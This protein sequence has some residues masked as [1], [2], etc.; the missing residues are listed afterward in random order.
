MEYTVTVDTQHVSVRPVPPV[1]VLRLLTAKEQAP[2]VQADGSIQVQ[3]ESEKYYH[4]DGE[5]LGTYAG[6]CNRIVTGLTQAGHH[7]V[8]HDER[9]DLLAWAARPGWYEVLA[10]M[11]FTSRLMPDLAV[12]EQLDAADRDLLNAVVSAWQGQIIVRHSGSTARGIALICHLYPLANILIP[13]ASRQKVLQLQRELSMWLEEPVQALFGQEANHNC[14]IAVCNLQRFEY[15]CPEDWSII[16]YPSEQEAIHRATINGVV[17]HLDEHRSYAFVMAKAK[18]NDR[19]ALRLEAASGQVIYREP[20]RSAARPVQVFVTKP[21]IPA[22]LPSCNKL[23]AF[24]RKQKLFW[25]ND[26]RNDAI[27]NCARAFATG[28]MAALW[29]LGLMVHE[30]ED[31]FQQWERRVRVVILVEVLEHA[32]QLQQRLPNWT[33]ASMVPGS[34]TEQQAPKTSDFSLAHLNRTIVTSVYGERWG[35]N[36]DIIIRADGTATG[37][38]TNCGPFSD[39]NNMPLVIIDLL[40]DLDG[41]AE[42][43]SLRRIQDYERRG[44]PVTGTP[45][46]LRGTITYGKGLAGSMTETYSS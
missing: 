13:V 11:P 28:D 14:R 41:R 2:V 20:V 10:D 33:I 44:W 29:D 36:A 8:L 19:A 34:I 16:L 37:W 6:L 45:N 35:I 23:S 43:E 9:P 46:R 3:S 40:D 32:R 5:R 31:W 12:L 30:K 17:P 15:I 18:L 24:E 7:V 42:R 4:V 1:D 21:P 39:I 26:S 25:H 22:S 27:A 38:N